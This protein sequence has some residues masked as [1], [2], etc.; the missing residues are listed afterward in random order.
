MNRNYS[1][2]LAR[3]EKEATQDLEKWSAI[4][5]SALKQ[6]ARIK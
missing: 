4:E 6:K 3:M 5:E 1:D 2:I